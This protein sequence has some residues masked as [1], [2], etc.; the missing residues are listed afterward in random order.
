V[1][2]L[3]E[4]KNNIL[5][6]QSYRVNLNWKPSMSMVSTM[7]L[8]LYPPWL[9]TEGF[10]L[11]S[12]NTI[13]SAFGNGCQQQTEHYRPAKHSNCKVK[14]CAEHITGYYRQFW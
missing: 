10:S 14:H 7:W 12:T 1:G 9:V 4:T 13:R 2:T 6:H 11:N 5:T 8:H 3:T